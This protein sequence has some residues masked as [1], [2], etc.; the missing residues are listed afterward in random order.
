MKIYKDFTLESVNLILR[1]PSEKDFPHIFSASR[2]E[3]FNDG[4]L[5]EPPEDYSDLIKPLENNIQAWE[6][7]KGYGFS[8]DSKVEQRFV[9]RVSIRE[10]SDTSLWNIGFWTHPDVQNRGIMTEAVSLIIK[11]GFEQLKAAMIEAEYATWNK[12]SEKVLLN[13]GFEFV[14]HIEKGFLKNGKWNAENRML[15]NRYT[16]LLKPH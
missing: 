10:T 5:W 16:W 7:G 1:I 12:A 4:M 15:I 6:E 11:F 2:H 13:N 9:G 3:G 14:E 8:I